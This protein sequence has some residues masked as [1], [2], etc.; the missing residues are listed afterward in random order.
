[1]VLR[2][3][4]PKYLNIL[5]LKWF[6]GNVA[7]NILISKWFGGKAVQYIWWKDHHHQIVPFIP[8][9][10]PPPHKKNRS[11]LHSLMEEILHQ[12][13]WIKHLSCKISCINSMKKLISTSICLSWLEKIKTYSPTWWFNGDESH[14]RK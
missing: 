12:L 6:W 8:S 13:T 7:P 11:I 3:C 4:C 2:E 5:I 14:G 1:M 10:T 9:Y